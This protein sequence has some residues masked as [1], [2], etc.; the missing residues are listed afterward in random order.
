MMVSKDLNV[1]SR[2]KTLEQP[3]ND[4]EALKAYARELFEKFLRESKLEARRVGVRV[5]GA[6]AKLAC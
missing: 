3:T 2:S 1:H 6:R 5:S 4:P